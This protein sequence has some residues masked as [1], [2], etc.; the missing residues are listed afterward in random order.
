M[1]QIIPAVDVLDG[2]VVRLMH[3]DYDRVTVYADDPVVQARSWIDQGAALVHVVDLAGAKSGEPDVALWE[4]LAAAGVTFQVG[5]GIRTADL[6]RRALEAGA[7]R[8]VMGTAAVWEPEILAQVGVP[9]AVVAA[10]DVKG[11]RATGAGWLDEGRALPDV[12][13]GLAGVGCERMLVTGIGRDGTMEGPETDLLRTVVGDGR[14]AVI[15][16]GGVGTL[17]DIAAVDAL[18][19]EGVIVGRALYEQRFTVGDAIAGAG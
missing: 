11:D 12:L 14:F 17:D 4:S 13:D 8:V 15:A 18:G 6:A 2:R 3:G 1:L 16:S 9:G 19:C 5:G 10:V 7:T